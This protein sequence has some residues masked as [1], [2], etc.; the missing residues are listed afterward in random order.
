MSI[1]VGVGAHAR[2]LSSL[3]GARMV[4]FEEYLYDPTVDVLN[5]MGSRRRRKQVW[6][7][8][9]SGLGCVICGDCCSPSPGLQV[10]HKAFVSMTAVLGVNILINTGAQI[11]HDCVIG[12]HCVIS[13]G[14]ILCGGVVLGQSVRIGAGAIVLQN[15][16]LP[17]GFT[18]EAGSVVYGPNDIRTP[19]RMVC[20]H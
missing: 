11:D 7:I 14:A 3:F 17:D 15:V 8:A 19:Q 2:Y 1:I 6:S 5:G 20:D 12:D 16:E 13:P 18:V 9:G 4:T 10:M